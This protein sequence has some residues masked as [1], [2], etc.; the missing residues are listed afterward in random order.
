MKKEFDSLNPYEIA[1]DDTDQYWF[2]TDLGAFYF[3][4]FT[5]SSDRPGENVLRFSFRHYCTHPQWPSLDDIAPGRQPRRF[6]Q[7]IMETIIW[8]IFK[9][10]DQDPKTTIAFVCEVEDDLAACRQRLFSRW[11]RKS[12]RF[13]I[14]EICK[15]DSE[16]EGNGY[17]SILIHRDHPHRETVKAIF[18]GEAFVTSD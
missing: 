14:H 18:L 3:A 1:G 15:Y 2:V 8:L 9:T 13:G 6:D 12:S 10:L 16:F 17:G 7:R 11:F 4:Y 5:H